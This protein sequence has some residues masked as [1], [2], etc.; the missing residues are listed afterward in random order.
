MTWTHRERVLAA[1]HHEEADRVPIDFG[2]LEFTSISK[3]AYERLKD[4]LGIHH[5]TRMASVKHGVAIPDE[6][7]K[8]DV[9][10]TVAPS[11]SDEVKKE[12][13]PPTVEEAVSD[14]S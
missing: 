1:L 13:I 2:A 6:A 5:K 7:K 11:D 9:P 10:A 4:H 3:A 12:L 14:A 8:P